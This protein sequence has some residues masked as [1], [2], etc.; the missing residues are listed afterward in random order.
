MLTEIKPKR[1][2]RKH[3]STEDFIGYCRAISVSIKQANNAFDPS[4][5]ET[6]QALHYIANIIYDI[7]PTTKKRDK[8]I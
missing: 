2:R 4:I 5:D 8:L 7:K 3:M 1:I 6:I